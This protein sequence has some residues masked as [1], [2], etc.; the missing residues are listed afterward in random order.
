[1]GSPA[2]HLRFRQRSGGAIRG[3]YRGTCSEPC[4]TLP[5]RPRLAAL[6]QIKLVDCS[7][8][9][10][11]VSSAGLTTTRGFGSPR[12]TTRSTRPVPDSLSSRLRLHHP[13]AVC[14]P[15]PFVLAPAR[16]RG[17]RGRYQ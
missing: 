6:P 11:I 8:S 14:Y 17:R 7:P 5:T 9:N 4:T 1:M 2:R 16:L 12:C 13:W 15:L 3:R 10:T